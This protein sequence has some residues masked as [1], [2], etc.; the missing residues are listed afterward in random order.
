MQF[1]PQRYG[2]G[3]R[4]ELPWDG[5]QK[6]SLDIVGAHVDQGRAVQAALTIRI[7]GG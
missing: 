7:G 4:L 2:K 3:C 1:M 5:D 6:M